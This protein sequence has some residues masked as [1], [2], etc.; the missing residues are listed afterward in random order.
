MKTKQSNRKITNNKLQLLAT[1]RV[2]LEKTNRLTPKAR[3]QV[4]GEEGGKVDRTGLG[5][6]DPKN[7]VS[8]LE[9]FPNKLQHENQSKSWSPVCPIKNV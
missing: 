3:S 5:F 6:T 7:L 4:E 9:T 8:K 2:F 1:S